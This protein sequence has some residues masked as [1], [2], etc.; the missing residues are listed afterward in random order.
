MKIL[1]VITNPYHPGFFKLK[2]SCAICNLPMKALVGDQGQFKNF[3]TKDQLTLQ[4]L[5]E[6]DEEEIILFTDGYDSLMLAG[7]DEILN[8]FY[9]YN[10][11]ILFSA[12]TCCYPD[13]ELQSSY[14]DANGSI[15]RYLNSGGFIGK[16]GAIRDLLESDAHRANEKFPFSNQYT[17]TL[18][19][20]ENQHRIKLDTSCSIFCTF[21]PEIT[22]NS[23]PAKAVPTTEMYFTQFHTW[24]NANFSIE[25][26]RIYNRITNSFP[27]NAHFNGATSVFF[28]ESAEIWDI[29]FGLIPGSKNIGLTAAGLK[30]PDQSIHP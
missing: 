15:Y 24:F 14:P 5:E 16:A 17:W 7:E 29:L 2:T 8:K 27:C 18:R 12:E 23:F 30:I 1:T 26:G 3:R 13:P 20:L 25:N 4:F 28:D 21:S 11:D 9:D 22:A 6:E 10:T 19:F